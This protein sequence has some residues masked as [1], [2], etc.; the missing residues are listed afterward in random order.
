MQSNKPGVQHNYLL[1]LADLSSTNLMELKPSPQVCYMGKLPSMGSFSLSNASYCFP[2]L[3]TGKVISQR[4]DGGLAEFTVQ[5]DGSLKAK[6]P[7]QNESLQP[8]RDAQGTLTGWTHVRSEDTEN[9]FD[10]SGKPV[11][12]KQRNGVVHRLTYLDSQGARYPA[13]APECH[14]PP[15]ADIGQLTPSNDALQCVTDSYGRQLN[16][17]YN[18]KKQLI[19]MIDPA[20]GSFRYEYN[21]P[22]AKWPPKMLTPELLTSVQYPDG[23]KRVYHYNEPEYT[24]EPAPVYSLTGI[25]DEVVPGSLV[26]YATFRYDANGRAISTEHAGGVDKFTVTYDTWGQERTVTDPLGT[27]R[28]HKFAEIAGVQNATG[29]TQPAGS[30]SASA[31]TSITY[32]SN[33]NLASR[34]DWN[35]RKTTYE[36]DP[37]RNLETKRVEAAGT[38]DARTISTEWHPTYRLPARIA[39]PKRITTHTYDTNGNLLSKTVQATSDANGTQ[40]FAAPAAGNPRTWSYT[41][42]DFGQVLTAT[43]ARGGVTTYSYDG[44][45]N[46]TNVKN[47][48]GH[49]T[50]LSNYDAHGRVGRIT[51]PNGLVTDLTYHPRGWIASRTVGGEQTMYDYDGVGQLKKVTLPDASFIAYTYDDARRLTGITDSAGNSIAYTLDAMGNRTK[52]EVKD[53]NG[54]LAGQITRVYDALNRLQQITGGVQ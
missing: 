34:T 38:A 17:F 42:N 15:S 30:G 54:I 16:F 25:S 45:G 4:E 31:S 33:G 5:A 24:A 32:H 7:Y 28:I 11:S 18:D 27:V 46:L 40:G 35:G 14:V 3:D 26:R 41:Y 23:R 37:V 10:A 12:V 43:D 8:R 44:Q 9:H 13:D 52:E 1:A 47:A 49:L 22:T 48:A 2:Y 50:L 53:P 20:G 19:L 29:Q 21:G 51:D 6:A 39:E 36:Y